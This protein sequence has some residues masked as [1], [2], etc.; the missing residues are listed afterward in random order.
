MRS[1]FSFKFKLTDR[2]AVTNPETSG[3]IDSRL[4][5]GGHSHLVPPH[6]E[7]CRLGV[8]IAGAA[9]LRW[10]V[11]VSHVFEGPRS[12]FGRLGH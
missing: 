1:P 6:S 5:L 2:F 9:G 10:G 4:I 3:M 12:A 11:A 7:F 8:T